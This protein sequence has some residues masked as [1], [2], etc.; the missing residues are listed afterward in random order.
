M[1]AGPA[2]YYEVEVVKEG[3]GQIGWADASFT[4]GGTSRT[5]EGVGDDK[6]SWGADLCRCAKWNNGSSGYGKEWCVAALS[7]SLSLSCLSRSC[8]FS[9]CQRC[10]AV[11]E[12]SL[13]GRTA[14]VG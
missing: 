2:Y 12:V 8:L 1:T 13:W 9:L 6:H 5:V 4:V 3:L 14:S 11:K 10:N 7:P